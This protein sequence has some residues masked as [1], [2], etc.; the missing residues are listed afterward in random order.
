MDIVT[1]DTA[2]PLSFM[3][4][5]EPVDT[6]A[7]LM[8]LQANRVSLFDRFAIAPIHTDDAI[9]FGLKMQFTGAV[10]GFAAFLAERRTRVDRLTVRAFL[11][12]LHLVG[13]AV[14]ADLGS[15]VLPFELAFARV[16]LLER[17]LCFAGVKIGFERDF[18]RR[19]C[20]FGC[21]RLGG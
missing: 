19:Y 4:A 5:A 14:G 8:T 12:G 11:Q 15:H 21:F 9:A 3:K 18:I 2:N 6:G 20:L 13:V 10:A 17:V 1:A 7:T 16:G